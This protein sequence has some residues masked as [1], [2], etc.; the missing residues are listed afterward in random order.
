MSE[1]TQNGRMAAV[2]HYIEA[3]LDQP[4]ELDKLAGVAFY[5]TFHFH[6]LFTSFTGESVYAYRKRLLL[7]RAVRYL[8]Y[9]ERPL[10][11]I[12]ASCGYE[13][14]ASFNKAFKQQFG[15]T[16]MQV[17]QEKILIN[18][19]R[20]KIGNSMEMAVTIVEQK[21]IDIICA[22]ATGSYAEAAPE[23]WGRVMRF[24]YGNRHMSPAVRSFGI[25]HDNPDVTEPGMI[26]YDAGL[27]LPASIDISAETGL[28]RHRIPAGRYAVF[29]HNGAYEKFVEAYHYIF[30]QWLP[31]SG[32]KLR[33]EPPFDNYLNRDPRKTKPE[34]LKTDIYIP[35]V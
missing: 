3:N 30:H 23:A 22:R 15:C 28:R 9:D 33:D 2:L 13:N 31:A 18:F 6:R 11:D 8:Q 7:E 26:R 27:D 12:A 10:L 1:F 17:R 29:R 35:L 19:S 14:Q 34:N 25:S 5:S 16:P 24:A 32:E 4:P 21:D 20:P